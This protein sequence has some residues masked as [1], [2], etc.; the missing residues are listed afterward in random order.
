M[1]SYGGFSEG[2]C[3]V[4]LLNISFFLDS[5]TGSDSIGFRPVALPTPSMDSVIVV[6]DGIIYELK[7]DESNCEWS[8][9][10]TLDKRD[11]AVALY[12]SDTLA[13]NNCQSV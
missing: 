4:Q 5:Y 1:G 8:T 7:C 3:V 10:K 11:Q 9:E 2:L 13:D 12:I 6:T